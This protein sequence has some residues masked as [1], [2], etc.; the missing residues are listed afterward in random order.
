MTRRELLLA[1][2]VAGATALLIAVVGYAAVA[3]DDAV[4]GHRHQPASATTTS[5]PTDSPVAAA[6]DDSDASWRL[7]RAPVGVGATF[8]LV[9]TAAWLVLR[10]R[11]RS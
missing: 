10:L 8:L 3:G 1:L 4:A 7:L 9:S 5:T 11:R 6:K 2:T